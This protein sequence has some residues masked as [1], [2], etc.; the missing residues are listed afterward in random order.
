M[1]V[2]TTGTKVVQ[3]QREKCYIFQPYMNVVTTGTKVVQAPRTKC[4]NDPIP[5]MLYNVKTK[6]KSR[7]IDN[8][9]LV[10]QIASPKQNSI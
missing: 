3:A 4:F 9:M 2:V 10:V 7:L 8:E 5:Q 1:N 6:L